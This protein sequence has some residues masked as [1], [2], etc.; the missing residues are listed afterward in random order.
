MYWALLMEKQDTTH[1]CGLQ[2]STPH[3]DVDAAPLCC[4]QASHE[5]ASA[6][7]AEM[8][9]KTLSVDPEVGACIMSHDVH[10]CSA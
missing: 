6:S 8:V 7:A 2:L 4:S 9:M 5:Y 1:G 3:H 10:V